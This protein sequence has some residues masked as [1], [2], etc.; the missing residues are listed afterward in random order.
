MLLGIML[1]H[2]GSRWSFLASIPYT[3]SLLIVG[4]FLG[5]FHV[6][7]SGG[8][9]TLSESMT[10]WMA[11]DPH[12]L[13]F[14]FLPVLLFGDAMSIVWHDFQRTAAQCA[15]LA[16]PGVLIGTALMF[17]VAKFIFPYGWTAY[18]CAAFGSVLAAT[19]PVAVVGLLKER[20]A[21]AVC[22]PCRSPGSPCSMMGSP[23][24]CGL[25]FTTS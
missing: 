10:L 24:S 9:G 25:C 6:E 1:T 11:I 5:L 4:V 3:V 22:S 8:L 2:L 16:G 14:G 13:L 12:L 7:T 17:V 18:E 15:I 19:D 20:W 23:S 21:R